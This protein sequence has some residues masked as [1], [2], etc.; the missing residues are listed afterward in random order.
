MRLGKEVKTKEASVSINSVNPP[1]KNSRHGP[2][3]SEGIS[4]LAGM[5]DPWELQTS[6]DS[7]NFPCPSGKL[8]TC[9]MK[10][11]KNKN[12]IETSINMAL[13]FIRLL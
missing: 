1:D 10:G 3:G 11:K 13:N 6:S 4:A 8:G 7:K 2:S 5:N 9:V 12:T